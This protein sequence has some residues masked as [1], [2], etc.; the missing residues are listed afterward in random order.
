MYEQ[1]TIIAVS[2]IEGA[3]CKKDFIIEQKL[4]LKNN[5]ELPVKQENS[6][7]QKARN[8]LKAVLSGKRAQD[9]HTA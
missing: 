9:K 7:V 3:R 4:D 8:I 1:L 5:P 6:P 2:N